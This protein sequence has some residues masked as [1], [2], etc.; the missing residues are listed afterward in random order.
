MLSASL[1][2]TQNWGEQYNTVGSRASIQKDLNKVEN[3]T[4]FNKIKSKS[5]HLGWDSS[6]HK[7]QDRND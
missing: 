4:K 1:Q 2:M 6:I 7:I 5:M 3:L